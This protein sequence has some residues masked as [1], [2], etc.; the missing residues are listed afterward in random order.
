M[1]HPAQ[2]LLAIASAH[3]RQQP[4]NPHRLN[5]LTSHHII[6]IDDPI[7]VPLLGQEPL[8]M[9]RVLLVHRVARDHRVEPCAASIGLR[10]QYAAQALR[11]LL[12]GTEGPDTWIATLASGR[13]TEKFATFDT[14]RVVISPVRKPS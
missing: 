2:L 7:R 3:D 8:P 14:T 9:R 4:A 5:L 1:R 6:R 11:F 12:A 13:S 10:P